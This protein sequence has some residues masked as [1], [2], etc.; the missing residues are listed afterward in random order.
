MI[1]TAFRYHKTEDS[2][3]DL[4]SGEQFFT[5]EEYSNADHTVHGRFDEYGQFKG[6][7]TIYGDRIEDHIIP[8]RGADGNPTA[9]GPFSI[10]FAAIEVDGKHS[11]LPPEDHAVMTRKMQQIGGLYIYRD[12]VRVL[13]YGDT[14][15]DWLDIEADRSKSASYYYFSHRKMF[16]VVD[17]DS[18]TNQ[19][20]NEKAG[21]E[22]FRENKAYRQF[23]RILKNFLVQ[24]AADFFRKEGM[25]GGQFQEKKEEL[26]KTELDRRKREKLV[27]ARK[28]QLSRALGQFFERLSSGAA[29]KETEALVQEFSMKLEAACA[30]E[31]KS[32]AAD[33]VVA[34]ERY[35][36]AGLRN[37]Q[38]KYKISRPRIGLSKAMQKEWR[39]YTTAYENLVEGVF[40]PARTKMEKRIEE[41]ASG[42]NIEVDRRRLVSVALEELS[43]SATRRT[44][45]RGEIA[46]RELNR[47]SLEVSE[48]IRECMR[49]VDE[50]VRAVASE[51]ERLDVSNTTDE[52]VV[53][54]RSA[55]ENR[56]LRVIEERTSLLESV[57]AQLEA[58]D[59]SGDS[60]TL[61]QLVAIEQ[62]NVLLEEEVDA[63]LQLAQ[64]GMAVEII[65]HEFIATVKSIRNNL[66]RLRAWADVNHG[67]RELYGN[68]RASFDHLD[69]YLTLFTPLQR[70]M[71]RR[72]VEIRGAEIYEFLRDLF[73]ERL[74]RHHIE[75]TRTTAFGR[76]TL[77]GFPS[78][79]YPVFVN[80]VDNAIYW[81]AQQ[82][83]AE[84]RH[85][86]LDATGGSL[87]VSD[88]GPGIAPRDREAIFEFG[89]TRKAG[90][91]GMGLH[92]CRETLR[93]VDYELA[94]QEQT[95]G[96][97]AT[98]VIRPLVQEEAKKG[99]E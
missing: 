23:K 68:L 85:I 74:P 89:F 39:D 59:A 25:Y 3:E 98:F 81:L 43:V 50:E 90:G 40:Q 76:A 52:V 48:A 32:V 55:L 80:L 38:A 41:R 4:I 67:I 8:W 72:P 19:Q 13:P 84:N 27:S 12:G 17:I 63:D 92:I 78:S 97:G 75:F 62:R 86:E 53:E 82:N 57:V 42:A 21:R 7:V 9:C 18:R 87:F 44:R 91:R 35:A 99:G 29:E 65:N 28:A 1:Q 16:G 30:I 88:T 22:G 61:D 11:T 51:F 49:G 31:D 95:E 56:I 24:M 5:V 37:L 69:G 20:L 33:D 73:R 94:L 77:R 46:R 60:S 10:C 64:L 45:E 15:Y 93:R 6:T 34:V 96:R 79:F 66:R 36:N 47:V 58:V 14:E 2:T 54:I 70:R 71:Y 83:L 26:E